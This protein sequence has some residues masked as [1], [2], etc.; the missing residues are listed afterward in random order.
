MDVSVLDSNSLDKKVIIW[1]NII[2]EVSNKTITS[3]LNFLQH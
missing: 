2:N 3:N 1:K